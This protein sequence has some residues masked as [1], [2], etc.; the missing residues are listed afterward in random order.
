[1]SQVWRACRR[2]D[3]KYH[4]MTE[5]LRSHNELLMA[6]AEQQHDSAV[7]QWQREYSLAV[8]EWES[9]QVALPPILSTH[10]ALPSL[11]CPLSALLLLSSPVIALLYLFF[12]CP[13][14]PLPA[15]PFLALPTFPYLSF[16]CPFPVLPVHPQSLIMSSQGSLPLTPFLPALLSSISKALLHLL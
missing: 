1:M 15:S 12:P 11:W 9:L 13:F 10:L 6:A 7:Q 4:R 8:M 2:S 14:L 16:P 5:P 3:E